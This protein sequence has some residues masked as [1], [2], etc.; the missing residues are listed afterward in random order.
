MMNKYYILI[1]I[2]GLPLWAFAQVEKESTLQPSPL[3]TVQLGYHLS[4]SKD[5]AAFSS[6]GVAAD[7]F[8]NSPSIDIAKALYGKIAGLN[9][10]QGTGPTSSNWASFSI[11][12]HAPLVLVD[13]FPRNISEITAAEIETCT[14]LKDAAAAALYGVRGANG[15][16]MITTKR[17]NA[18]RLNVS[19]KYQFGLSTQF[20]N[21]EFADAYTYASQLNTALRLDGLDNKYSSRELEAFRDGTFPYAYPNVNWWDESYNKTSANHR[22]VLTFDGGS[23]KF[24]YYT[25]LDYMHDKGLFRNESDDDR[26]DPSLT[27]VQLNVHTNIDVEITKSTFFK[28]GMSGKLFEVNQPNAGNIYSAIYNTPSAVFPV[29]Q[30]DGIYGGNAIYGEKNPVALLNSTGN[31]RTTLGG[32]LMNA[33]LKQKLDGLLKGLSAELSVAFDDIGSMYDATSKTYRYEDLHP[34]IINRTLVTNPVIYG[35]DSEVIS[36]SQNF[37]SLYIRSSFQGKINYGYNDNRHAVDASLIYDQNS[38]TANGRNASTKRQS[39][40]ATATYSYEGRYVVSGV[41]NY[42]GSA[43]LPSGH[44]FHLYPAVSASWNL[45]KEKFMK[46]TEWMNEL[47]LY[48]SYGVSGWD[49][50]LTHELYRQSYGS[51]E[52]SYYFTNNVSDK[53]GKGEGSLPVLGLTVEKSQKATL[54]LTFAALSNRLALSVDGFYEKRSDILTPASTVSGIIGIDVGRLNAG[55]QKYGGFDAS[56]SWNDRIGNN[57]RYGVG[58]NM[59]YVTSKVIEDNQEYQ[60]YDYLYRKGNKVGQQY[61]LEV[62]GF[63]HDQM[64]INNSPQQLFSTVRPGDIKYKDQ[65][66]DNVIN[67]LD[68]VKMFGSS[69]PRFYFG[70]NLNLSYK[71]FAISADFQ[72]L[73]G[74]TV[75]LL[76][77]PLYTPL[78][79]N[80][81]ISNTF[82]DNEIPWTPENAGRATM[83]R[84]TTLPNANNYS[85]NSLWYRDGSFIKLRNLQV[86]YLF[87]KSK[88]RFADLRIYLQGTDL[89]SLDNLGTMDPEQLGASYPS[90][91]SYWMGLQFNF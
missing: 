8:E 1:L 6:A 50:N 24:R 29:R 39:V 85:N 68:V 60:Q 80:G 19:A 83:P 61:G 3:D 41:L 49:G 91:R 72:G 40:L 18:G 35:K 71:N 84:L 65:N 55:I 90:V 5:A 62:E 88:N 48:A 23:S 67:S 57:I 76:N 78:V 51:S 70:V 56:V 20:R 53:Y 64:E 46:S 22:L 43:Y 7:V 82:L 36:H 66:G 32:V 59:S 87:P 28:L 11:H 27:Y 12:G 73:T 77:S 54:G 30:E 21:P 9:V 15:V 38:Y 52:T 26:Y 34:S 75:N 17:G 44:R 86:S 10:Y 4:F 25:V 45:S 37:S 31:T 33:N 81:N 58:A 14:I 69:I 89:F 13:G 63:F 2:C 47:K 16:V 79:S 42:S 74:K